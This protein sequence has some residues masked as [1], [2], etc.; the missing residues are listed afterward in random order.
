MNTNNEI[1]K[2]IPNTKD[3]YQASSLG[4]IKSLTKDVHVIMKARTDKG[5]YNMVNLWMDGKRKTYRVHVLVMLAFVG[6]TPK[7]KQIDHKDENKGNN[8]LDNL[9]FLSCR[10]NVTK[11]Q[12]KSKKSDYPTGVSV[13]SKHAYRSM[14]IY[15][16][17]KYHLGVD[18]TPEQASERYQEA[19]RQINNGTFEIKAFRANYKKRQNSTQTQHKQKKN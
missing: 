19:L 9:Q 18:K 12:L 1:W 4:R 2:F 16:K 5:D 6:E 17:Y 3:R 7:G 14:I 8:S 15:Q 13:S 10:K 11:A